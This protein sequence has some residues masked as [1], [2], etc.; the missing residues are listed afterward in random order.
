MRKRHFAQDRSLVR[1][2]GFFSIAVFVDNFF[3]FFLL[4]LAKC[5]TNRLDQCLDIMITMFI[6][7]INVVLLTF[8]CLSGVFLFVVLTESVNSNAQVLINVRNN[9]KLLG[10]VKAFD[11]HCNMV[12]E[13]VKGNLDVFCFVESS[14]VFCMAVCCFSCRVFV[15]FAICC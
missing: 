3:F 4:L 15:D 12:L 11:R 9:R 2:G 13:N 5:A 7:R 14:I 10:R 8:Y 1:S 6:I